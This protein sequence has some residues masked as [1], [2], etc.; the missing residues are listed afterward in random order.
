MNQTDFNDKAPFA[1]SG[2][3]AWLRLALLVPVI[4]V[5]CLLMG[6]CSIYGYYAGLQ[7][8]TV[9]DETAL[10]AQYLSNQNYLSNYISGFYEQIG[11][12]NLKSERLDTILTDAVK[13]RYE[14]SGGFAPNGA[15]FSAIQEAYPDLTQNMQIYDKIVDYIQSH[16]E[17]YRGIQDKLLD[18]LRKYDRFRQSGPIQS[19]IIRNFVGAPTEALVARIGTTS[20]TGKDALAQMWVIVT[21]DDT[22]KAYQTG[23]MAPLSVPQAQPKPAPAA[24]PAAAPPAKK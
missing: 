1:S 22:Q 12:A 7:Q 18:M 16:R 5:L 21:T 23:T 8:Q 19:M 2:R 14:S 24:V 13:G 20:K 6:G 10:N 4:I 9:G 3:P 17:G 15:F 11:V